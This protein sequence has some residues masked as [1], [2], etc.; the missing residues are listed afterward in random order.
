MSIKYPENQDKTV[1]DNIGYGDCTNDDNG[2]MVSNPSFTTVIETGFGRTIR[3]YVGGYYI[4][5]IEFYETGI[6]STSYSNTSHNNDVLI[7][8]SGK[9][10]P[11]DYSFARVYPQTKKR[12]VKRGG[13]FSFLFSYW[14]DTED[15]STGWINSEYAKSKA[16]Q[17]IAHLKNDIDEYEREQDK[18]NRIYEDRIKSERDAAKNL[19]AAVTRP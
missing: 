6:L 17:A 14:K 9:D 16:I 10:N 3:L 15:R 19:V 13:V 4:S 12:W 2:R 8:V 7:T 11:D 5:S 18:E 1:I